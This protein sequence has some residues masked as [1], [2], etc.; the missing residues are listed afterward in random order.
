[1]S[2][3]QSLN[4]ALSGL[5]AS[6]K[7]AEATSSNLS[8]ALTEGYGRR[9]VD[10]ASQ[11]VGGAGAGVTLE[12][13]T[14]IKDKG[15]L[16]DRR[17]SDAE[18][19]G[20]SQRSTGLVALERTIG[21]P[22]DNSGLANRIVALEAALTT[23]AAEPA[24]DLRLDGVLIQLEG[25]ADKLNS[26]QDGIQRQRETVDRDIAQQVDTLNTTLKQIEG[27]N[28]NIARSEIEGS[29]SAALRDQRQVAVDKLSDIVPLRLFER[30]NGRIAIMSTRG[31]MLLD[32][33]APTYDFGRTSTIM[34]HMT[35]AAGTLS[36]V[37]RD[38]TPFNAGF[39]RLQGGSLEA[40]FKLRDET[41]VDAQ[42]DLDAVARDLMERF[43][44]TGVDPSRGTL[45]GLLTDNG[46]AFNTLNASGLAGRI[47]VNAA[48]DPALGGALSR[49]RDG[50]GAATPGP[51]GDGAQINRW[52]DGLAQG[53]SLASGGASETA[54]GH[55]AS[56]AARIGADRVQAEQD[57]AFASGRWSALKQAELADGVDTDFEMQMLLRV[58]QAY[59]ANARVIQTVQAMMRELMEI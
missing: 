20:F 42:T 35:L 39:G 48:V 6:A 56:F 51:V 12:G 45:P 29:D 52:L 2:M 43:E 8:N 14:R 25:L 9:R 37:S 13:I 1:M 54:A 22:E 49:L 18:L 41:L 53:R 23:A 10:L 58:E 32:G 19:G 57:T 21:R 36:G 50:V 33:P 38:G 16:A 30:E 40:A 59:A 24:S 34:P 44:D 27:L 17:L 15:I 5:N 28:T 7:L 11:V 4:N 46:A 55:A 31:E 26:D 47:S 3:T